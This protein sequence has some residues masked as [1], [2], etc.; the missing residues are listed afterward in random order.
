MPTC[1]TS[2]PTHLPYAGN[3]GCHQRHR[4][5]ASKLHCLAARWPGALGRGTAARGCWVQLLQLA[6]W[7]A[8]GCS[9]AGTPGAISGG[10]FVTRAG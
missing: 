10:G 4:T 6:S 7:R 1:S 5:T 9:W 3:S 2:I 8:G